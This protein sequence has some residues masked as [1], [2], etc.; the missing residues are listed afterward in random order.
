MSDTSAMTA[1][2]STDRKR[3]D[4]MTEEIKATIDGTPVDQ[5][6]IINLLRCLDEKLGKI[7]ELLEA[8]WGPILR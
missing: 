1:D 3:G 4:E 7:L 6:V 2:C 5:M 8:K